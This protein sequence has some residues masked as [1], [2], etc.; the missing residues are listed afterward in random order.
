MRRRP[1]T[2]TAALLLSAALLSGADVAAAQPSAPAQAPAHD[3]VQAPVQAPRQAPRQAPVPAGAGV[4]GSARAVPGLTTLNVGR[5]SYIASM[6]CPAAGECSAGG[7]YTDGSGHR[8]AF[9]VDET[10]GVWGTALEVPGTATLNAGG[11]AAVTQVSCAVVGGC[12]AGGY[13]T[14][15]GGRQ[16]AFVVN[17]ASGIWGT[18]Q[19]APGTAVLNR[20]NPGAELL[21][22]SCAAAGECGAGGY[23]SDASGGRQAFVITERRGTWAPAREV[24]GTAALN[25]GGFGAIASVSC[26]A[27]GNCGA[28]GYYAS[29]EVD[30]V[31]TQQALVVSEANGVW[32]TGE[33]VPGTSVL[34]TGGYAGIYSVSCASAG[35]CTAAGA[36]TNGTYPA[37]QTLVVT[38][39]NGTWGTGR[40]IP[41]ITALNRRRLAQVNVVSCPAPGSCGAGGFYQDAS[42]LSQAFVADATSGRWGTGEEAPGTAVLNAA[43]PGASITSMSCASPGNCTAGGF[44][45]EA[46]GKIQSFVVTEINGVW[47]AAQEVPGVAALNTGG[48]AATTSVSCASPGNCTVA[49]Q[50]ARARSGVEV[51]VA[52]ETSGR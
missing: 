30:G 42:Y 31:P 38:E 25:A 6:S 35:N 29:S 49:G 46:S 14:S 26:S 44:L 51:F 40:K 19:E 1:A 22:V 41:G 48:H 2:M 10:N 7:Y 20:G 4:W 17:R 27:G 34:N 45:T 23:Y 33:E 16:Q 13:Y 32:G 18:A 47:T 28:G 15:G 36:Y 37:T 11:R 21:S 24:P 9:V 5:N 43:S 39:T 3:T 50:Y 8:Q 52:S 12:A